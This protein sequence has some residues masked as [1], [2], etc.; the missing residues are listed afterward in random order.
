MI[1]VSLA[2][3]SYEE[4]L[5]VIDKCEFAEIRID[6]LDF[7]TD[8][9]KDLFSINKNT[10]ATCRN[11][12]KHNNNRIGLLKMAILAGAKYVDIEFETET[13]IR[14]EITEFAHNHNSLL[15]LS[16]HNFENTPDQEN[17]ELIIKQ[18]LQWNADLVKIVTTAINE[19]DCSVVMSLY[20]R[21]KNI[22][23]FCMG[24]HGR[25]TRV[26]APFLG[27]KFTYAAWNDNLSTAPGQLT[28]D[29]MERIYAII[30]PR[31]RNQEPGLETN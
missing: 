28:V 15:I 21:Y 29:E 19:N 30:E 3:L 4:C 2:G 11:S 26:A 5:N 17:L 9:L 14:E 16:Y 18:S 12:A 24:D 22:I 31:A 27:A 20:A 13:E 7:P 8:Q 6:L 25:I 10:I 1:C 23:A